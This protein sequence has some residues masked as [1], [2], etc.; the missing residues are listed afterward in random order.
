MP[1]KPESTTPALRG[2]A[3][4]SPEERKAISAKGGRA[5]HAKGTAHEFDSSSAARAGAKGGKEAW[6][7]GKAHKFTSEEAAAAGAK[8]GIVPRQGDG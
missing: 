6:K 2:L 7:R 8:G 4:L 5:A 1:D 3:R